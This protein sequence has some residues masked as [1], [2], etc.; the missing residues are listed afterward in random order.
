MEVSDKKF[1]YSFRKFSLFLILRHI[2][3]HFY[4]DLAEE[5]VTLL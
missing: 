1:R 4:S 3:L 2:Y 5:I